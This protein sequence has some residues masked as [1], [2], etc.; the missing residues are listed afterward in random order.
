M[1][2]KLLLF[3]LALILSPS[4]IGQQLVISEN[5][6]SETSIPAFGA[7]RKHFGHIFFG[8]HHIAGTPE[9]ETDKLNDWSSW[10]FE[11]GYRYKRRFSQTLSAGAE[12]SA[13]RMSHS[14]KRWEMLNTPEATETDKHKFILTQAGLGLYQ[15]F[16][17]NKRRGNYIGNYIDVGVYGNWN[18]NARQIYKFRNDADEKVVYKKSNLDYINALDYGILTRLGFNKFAAKA[19]YRLSDHFNESSD[20]GE[21]PRFTFGVEFGMIFY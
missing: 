14:I 21:F 11:I 6:K 2:Q 9:L 7:N 4:L 8:L 3:V 12:F 17:Y 10:A 19:T 18:F 5:L 15:R 20:L 1:M 16:N 13:K